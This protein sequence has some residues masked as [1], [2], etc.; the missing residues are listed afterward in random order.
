MGMPCFGAGPVLLARHGMVKFSSMTSSFSPNAPCLLALSLRRIAGSG[1]HRP[2][3]YVTAYRPS[4]IWSPARPAASTLNIFDSIIAQTSG[5]SEELREYG[6]RGVKDDPFDPAK[7]VTA[8]PFPDGG[9]CLRLG[10]R[11]AG[12]AKEPG[13]SPGGF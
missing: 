12:A 11:T 4:E 1:K 8:H 9:H 6:Y 7:A 2:F 5:F 10:F 13:L 3:I